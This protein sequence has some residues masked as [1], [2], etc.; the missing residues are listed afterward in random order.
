MPTH[1]IILRGEP[2]AGA[3]TG[4]VA[5]W[6]GRWRWLPIALFVSA[7]GPVG[8]AQG[9]SKEYQLKAAFLFNFTKFVEWPSERFQNETS[10]IIIAVLGHNPFDAELPKLVEGRSVHGRMITVRHIASAEE[11]PDAHVLYVA[12]GEEARMDTTIF[13]E[14]GVLTVGESA[15]FAERGGIIR[16]VLIDEKVRFAINQDS[17]ERAGLKVSAELLKLATD[18]HE[19]R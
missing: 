2:G 1:E 18:L 17:G 19:P 3:A 6:V 8:W 16:F 15:L 13:G 14:A 10:P 9:V 5:R 12:A 4:T 11:I 7:L